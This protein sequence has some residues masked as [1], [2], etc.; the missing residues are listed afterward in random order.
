MIVNQIKTIES[1]KVGKIL[2]RKQHTELKALMGKL[3]WVAIQTRPDVCFEV[4]MFLAS[5][6]LWNNEQPFVIA[7][8]IV[9]KLDATAKFCAMCFENPGDPKIWL[10]TAYSDA[11][12][13]NL[14]SRDTQAGYLVFLYGNLRSK[15][16]INWK[17]NCLR[18]VVRST[19]KGETL[20]CV[21]AVETALF[22][23]KMISKL[24]SVKVPVKAI[25]DNRSV[26]ESVYSTKIPQDK[27]LRIENRL[28]VQW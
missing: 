9:R 17:S 23:Q 15:T 24:K 26:V 20:F 7:N 16:L 22:C 5:S 4:N 2:S 6:D 13:G 12:L 14:P 11:S 1:P 27:R 10:I 3:Q 28:S 21:I 25:T 19:A 8:E 18:R